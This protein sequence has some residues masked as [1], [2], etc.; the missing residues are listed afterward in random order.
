[1][2]IVTLLK[3]VSVSGSTRF[4]AVYGEPSSASRVHLVIGQAVSYYEATGLTTVLVPGVT[5]PS[6]PVMPGTNGCTI[7]VIVAKIEDEH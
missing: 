4:P 1:M 7:S 2:V 6:S 3:A 5:T